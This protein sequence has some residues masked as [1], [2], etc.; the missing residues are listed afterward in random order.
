MHC[1]VVNTRTECK[2]LNWNLTC[3]LHVFAMGPDAV[4]QVGFKGNVHAQIQKSK[5]F[6]IFGMFIF[7]GPL[8]VM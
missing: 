1:T 6:E 8:P 4:D 2:V 5:M 7:N 3:V